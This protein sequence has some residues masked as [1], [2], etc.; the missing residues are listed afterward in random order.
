VV[1]RK[2][3]GIGY[4]SRKWRGEGGWDVWK[5]L[6]VKMEEIGWIKSGTQFLPLFLLGFEWE[7][8]MSDGRIIEG[9]ELLLLAHLLAIG[10]SLN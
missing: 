9:I 8:L 5:E 1:K 7:M 4:C 6:A 10:Q 2:E 3:E